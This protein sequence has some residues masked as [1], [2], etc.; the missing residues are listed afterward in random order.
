ML[1]IISDIWLY[2]KKIE[3]N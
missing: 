3:R 2:E 1:Y